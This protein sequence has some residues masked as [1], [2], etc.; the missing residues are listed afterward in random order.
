MKKFLGMLTALIIFSMS[1][2]PKMAHAENIKAQ[3][4]RD[5][6]KSNKYYVE[7]EVNTKED[8]RALAVDGDL[9]KSFDCEGRRSS[10]LL[11]FIPIVGLFAK[12]S[13]KLMPEVFYDANNYYQFVNK[14]KILRATPEE[15][16][17]PY[18][19]PIQEWGTVEKRIVLPEEFGMFTG[20]EEIKFVESG[21]TTD[22]KNKTQAFDKY[23]KI[24]KNINGANIA[25]KVYMVYYNEKGEPEKILTMTVDWEEDAGTIF[26]E[27]L[28]KKPAEQSYDIQR[29]KINKFTGELPADVMNFPSGSKVYGADLGNMDE[30]LDMPPLLEE[31]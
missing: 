19:D 16:K 12:G 31:H 24:I 30:L 27:E 18:L 11:R 8:K 6:I 26:E 15:L 21:T 10:T 14:K 9:R 29:I 5:I 2:M 1:F 20:D 7:Y 23:L 3:E 17:D 22:D 28:K 4:L 25:K 13:L